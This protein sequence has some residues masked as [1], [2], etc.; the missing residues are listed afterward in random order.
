MGQRSMK[1]TDV[2][3]CRLGTLLTCEEA[4]SYGS[5][6]ERANL[7]T[8][9]E[10]AEVVSAAAT[11]RT[12]VTMNSTLVLVDASSGERKTCTLVYPEDRDL[13]PHS[14]GIL[15]PLGQRLLGRCVGD[16]VRTN[17]GFRAKLFRIETIVYQPEAAGAGHL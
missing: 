10:E 14:V 17:E 4:A 16:I 12:L 7:E 2:D 3:R 6:R 1:L 5:A 8:K 13:M 11:P 15:Q 9:L